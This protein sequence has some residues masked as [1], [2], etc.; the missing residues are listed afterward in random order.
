MTYSDLQTAVT[1]HLHRADLAAKMPGF[2]ALAEAYLFRELQVKEMQISVTGTTTGGYAPLPS[3]FGTLSRITVTYNGLVRTLDYMARPDT[4]TYGSVFPASYSLENNQIRIFNALDG[5]AYTLYYIP[6][7]QPLS[8]TVSTNWLLTNA[9]DLYFY[10]SALE[11]AKH[12]RNQGEIDK[13]TPMIPPLLDSVK[14]FSERRA[15]PMTGALQIK[16]RR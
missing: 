9:Y 1:A 13:L 7:I 5:Q 12:V 16:P 8:N 6:D 3:D 14:R 10:A 4:V 15:Q 2:I 11:G